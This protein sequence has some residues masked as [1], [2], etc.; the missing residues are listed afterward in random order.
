MPTAVV[1]HTSPGSIQQEYVV[2]FENK[3]L[4][5]ILGHFQILQFYK[6]SV[7]AQLTSKKV[8]KLQNGG[9][10]QINITIGN[11]RHNINF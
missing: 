3:N 9:N 10:N 8:S 11:A 1:K 7:G 6:H 5:I 4:S 2:N